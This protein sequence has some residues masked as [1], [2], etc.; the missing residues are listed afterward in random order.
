MNKAGLTPPRFIKNMTVKR[1]FTLSVLVVVLLVMS[2]VGYLRVM[3]MEEELAANIQ[4]KIDTTVEL[5]ALSLSEPLWNF[6]DNGMRAICDALFKDRDIGLVVVKTNSGREIYRKHLSSPIYSEDNLILVER[7]I[8]KNKTNLGSVTIGLTNYYN[9][10]SR[11]RELV[12]IASAIGVMSLILWFLI[13]FVS[14][15]VTKPIYELSAGTEEI[16]KGN[17]D[18][19]LEIDYEDEIGGL[20]RKFNSMAENLTSMMKELEIK[21]TSLLA[22]IS[23]RKQAQSALAASEEKFFKAFR[24]VADIIGIVRISDGRYIEINDA[25]TSVLGYEKHE[26][27]GHTSLDFGLW[28]NVQQYADSFELL[29]TQGGFRDLEVTWRCKSGEIRIGLYSAE[30]IEIGGE[31]YN[32]YVWHDITERK[33]TE[34]ELRYLSEHDTLTGIYNRNYFEQEVKR[35]EAEYSG[36]LSVAVIMADT[37]GLKLINDTLGPRRRRPVAYSH[38]KS[39]N[40]SYSPGRRRRP[41]RRGRIRRDTSRFERRNS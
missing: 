19:R 2:I 21:N 16:A 27:I 40:T 35:F 7:A 38:R 9:D 36:N 10:M 25:F 22:E 3:S 28:Q 23:E 29:R 26:V 18:K 34:E 20:A 12:T 30:V 31:A 4:T 8:A 33:Q 24:Y 17:L 14:R 6:N 13:A 37:D 39:D 32:V 15:M 41:H 1:R 5:A 11:Q